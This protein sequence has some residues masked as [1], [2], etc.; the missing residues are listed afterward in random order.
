MADEVSTLYARIVAEGWGAAQRTMIEFEQSAGRAETKLA[1]FN[2]QQ[3]NTERMSRQTRFAIGN[4]ANQFGDMAV[5]IDGGTS[6]IK[7]M[8]QQLPQLFGG[9]GPMGAVVGTVTALALSIGNTLFT[10]MQ[11][12]KVSA[13]ALAEAEK[14]LNAAFDTAKDGSVRLSEKLL[15]LA[16]VSKEAAEAQLTM[17]QQANE[18]KKADLMDSIQKQA[19]SLGNFVFSLNDAAREA[20]N[21]ATAGKDLHSILV[22]SNGAMDSANAGASSLGKIMRTLQS[23]YGLTTQQAAMFVEK[24]V[25]FQNDKSPEKAAAL[26][27]VIAQLSQQVGIGNRAWAQYAVTMYNNADAMSKVLEQSV[28]IDTAMKGG[29]VAGLANEQAK[30]SKDRLD[31]ILAQTATG[32]RSIQLQHEQRRK[33]IEDDA[34]LTAEDKATALAADREREAYDVAQYNEREAK[35]DERA[36]RSAEKEAEREARERQRKYDAAQK[37][38][39]DLLRAEE[40]YELTAAEKEEVYYNEKRVKVRGWLANELITQ[41]QHDSA[42]ETLELTHRKRLMDI[43]EKESYD[44]AKRKRQLEEE[45]RERTFRNNTMIINSSRDMN[46]QLMTIMEQTGHKKSALYKAMFLADKMMALASVIV[47]TQE[48]A[49]KAIGQMG[50][51]GIP[52]VSIIEAMGAAQEGIILG[53]AIGGMFDTGGNI[54]SGGYGIVGENGPEIVRG[55]ANVTDRQ[56]T[57]AL[58]RKALDG[59]DGTSVVITQNITISGTGDEKLAQAMRQAAEQGAR[60]GVAMVHKDISSNGPI[61]RKLGV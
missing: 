46:D 51:F 29:D 17:A 27:D 40:K 16:N 39:S 12:A 6:V 20:A 32:V 5:Q 60:Q 4:A 61:R 34:K 25:D 52:M 58:A 30:A 38:Y 57:A 59:G 21:F 26:K 36:Q 7:T 14:D 28:K 11:D 9:F 13:G 55:P 24:L 49:S 22:E 50:P 1:T 48:G 10:A 47:N 15:D 33:A 18:L 35:K 3:Q 53:T 31:T 43:A 37:S 44:N 23:D 2:T 8:T 41:R 54:P 45:E 42:M 56:G 19:D